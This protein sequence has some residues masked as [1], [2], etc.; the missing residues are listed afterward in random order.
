MDDGWV[1]TT[2]PKQTLNMYTTKCRGF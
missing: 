1:V 2:W